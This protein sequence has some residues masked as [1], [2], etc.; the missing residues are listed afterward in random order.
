MNWISPAKRAGKKYSASHDA[1]KRSRGQRLAEPCARDYVGSQAKD[2]TSG[3]QFDYLVAL[4][5]LAAGTPNSAKLLFR[6][7]SADGT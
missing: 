5:F 3:T 6:H 4:P 2:N 7:E 1:G